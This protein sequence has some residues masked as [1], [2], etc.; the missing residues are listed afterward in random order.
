MKKYVVEYENL[1]ILFGD[2]KFNMIVEAQNADEAIRIVEF[3]KRNYVTKN[4]KATEIA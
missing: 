3:E 1:N 2:R 4:Y